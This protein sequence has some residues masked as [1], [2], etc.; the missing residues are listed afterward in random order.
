MK[1][2]VV[3][4]HVGEVFIKVNSRLE[5]PLWFLRLFCCVPWICYALALSLR[6]LFYVFCYK[7]RLIQS[8]K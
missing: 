5:L 8:K 3:V 2:L 1:N 7:K 6:N 4:C